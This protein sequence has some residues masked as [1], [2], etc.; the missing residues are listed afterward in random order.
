MNIIRDADKVN[1]KEKTAVTLGKFDGLHKG[2]QKL[3]S[4]VLEYK[5]KGLTS[6]VFTFLDY[7]LSVLSGTIQ[8]V[9]LTE[10]EKEELLRQTG[11]DYLIEYPFDYTLMTMEPEQFVKEILIDKLN[12]HVI[13]V[14]SDFRFG[15]KR[16]GDVTLL[17]K[18]STKYN[19]QLEVIEKETDELENEVS[20]TYIRSELE[21]GN[22]QVVNK[23]L[24]GT[25]FIMGE[26]VHGMKL[27]RTLGYPTMNITIEKEKKIP[28]NGVYVATIEIDG[29]IYEAVA[30]IGKKPTVCNDI[31]PILEVHVFN[32]SQ[33]TYGKTVIVKL[34]SFV[35]GEKKFHS[36]EKL[37]AQ[38]EQ[39][40]AYAKEYFRKVKQ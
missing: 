8:K 5:N 31:Q 3:L 28:P 2:H 23:L 22:I 24:G 35:R 4:R 30:N 6:V 1:I 21:K 40:V 27:A 10:E 15:Y 12:C 7:P 25:Y 32:Y 36:V 13:V 18:L 34:Y 9:L 19:Y 20:S 33:D 29:K 16:K 37:K 11:V 14:G 26:V 17:K 39:D 38:M